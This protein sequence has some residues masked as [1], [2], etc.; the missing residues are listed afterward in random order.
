YRNS[1]PS[2]AASARAAEH[3]GVPHLIHDKAGSM[4]DSF[5]VAVTG[6]SLIKTDV[7]D[8]RDGRFLEVLDFLEQG[9]VVFTNF[10]STILG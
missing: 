8:I 4:K 5:C 3:R 10:E 1:P 6:Q 2:T 7:S 9:D